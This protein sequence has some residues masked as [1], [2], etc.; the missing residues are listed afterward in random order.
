MSTFSFFTSSWTDWNPKC[1]CLSFEYPE[2]CLNAKINLKIEIIGPTC[3]KWGK[4]QSWG[5][6]KIVSRLL[7][8]E[9]E[10]AY[11]RGRPYF[12]LNDQHYEINL[13]YLR[14]HLSPSMQVLISIIKRRMNIDIA[15]HSR[16]SLINLNWLLTTVLI[17]KQIENLSRHGIFQN[18]VSNEDVGLCSFL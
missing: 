17:D 15:N 13:M 7:E 6:W 2:H 18:K 3:K 10:A 12:S 16:L 9:W 4:L 11:L 1:V 5:H 8:K 14:S